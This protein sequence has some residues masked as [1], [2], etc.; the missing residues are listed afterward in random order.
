MMFAHAVAG[1]ASTEQIFVSNIRHIRLLEETKRCLDA[2]LVSAKQ[3]VPIDF[4]GIDV[5][6]A[7]H[8]LAQIT[9]K[10]C[11]ED[12]IDTIF[13]NFCVGK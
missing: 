1:N 13:S 3:G 10:T 9:G 7:W 2:G 5:Q 11:D 8:F 6:E 4:L 12:I